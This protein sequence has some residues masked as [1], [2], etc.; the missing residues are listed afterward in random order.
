MQQTASLSDLANLSGVDPLV[1]I[2]LDLISFDTQADP[3]SKA[4]PSSVG[5]L[6]FGAYLCS[7]IR[8]MGFDARQDEKGLVKVVIKASEGY[9]NAKRLCLFA[10][11]D[12]APDAKG[13]D[14][15]PAL[16]RNYHGGEIVLS[17]GLVLNE[18]ISPELKNC[19][20]QDIIVTDGNT[21]LGA[22]DKAGISCIMLLLHKIS[23]DA[24]FAHGPLTVVFTVDEEIGLS[25]SYVDVK[26]IDCDYGLTVDGTAQGELDTGT[27]NAYGACVRFTGVSVHTA[28]AY[29]KLVNAITLA[30]EFMSM[31]PRDEKPENTQKDEGFFHVHNIEGSVSSCKV[32]MIIRDFS[33][34]GMK[35]RLAL[36]DDIVKLMQN[37]YGSEA[38]ELKTSFQYS[39]MEEVLK[40]VPEYISLLK[41]AYARAGAAVCENR[42][43]G[44]TD[45]S[46][47]SVKGLPTP[48]MFTGALNCHGPYECLPVASFNKAYQVLLNTVSLMADTKR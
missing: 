2:F 28:V 39:N 45:G 30:N 37:K 10:H 33:S 25:S 7:L 20:G 17:S 29:K 6:R 1:K 21:L 32:N 36:L 46:N 31:L 23:T 13:A 34:D 11:M 9:E 38:V 16:V 27:F 43:R 22:D 40:T 44:G 4:V 12:T 8:D 18:K 47:L 24:N 19:I 42:V 15:T 14:V 5:Q 3:D 48:N 35:K 41:E 26:E